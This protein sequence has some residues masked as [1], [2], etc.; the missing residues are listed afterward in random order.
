MYRLAV[1]A[2]GNIGFGG[3]KV[4]EG[5]YDLVLRSVEGVV[6]DYMSQHGQD[7]GEVEREI[8]CPN[9][10]ALHHHNVAAT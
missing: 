7:C 4:W 3:R 6:N 5:G 9:C 8:V 2:K 10:L 1:S